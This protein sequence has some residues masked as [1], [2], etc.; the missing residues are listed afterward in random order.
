MH[1]MHTD[2]NNS[3]GFVEIAIDVTFD[4]SNGSQGHAANDVVG[5]EMSPCEVIKKLA[6]G[7]MKP[8]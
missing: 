4:E 7:E 8:Q 6:I 5:N 1:Q 3:T 2:T